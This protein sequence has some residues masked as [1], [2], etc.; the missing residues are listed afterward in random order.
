MP[1]FDAHPGYEFVGVAIAAALYVMTYLSVVRT[2]RY[3]RNWARLSFAALS[4]AITMTFLMLVH[5]SMSSAGLDIVTLCVL[6]GFISV[7]FY[8][9]SAPALAFKPASRPT[10]FLARHGEYAGLWML[11]PAVAAVITIP[12]AKLHAIV[13][14]AM[15]IELAWYLQYR[16]TKKERVLIPITGRDLA[17]LKMQ[18]N[19]DIKSYARRHGI[20]E[21]ELTG[22]EVAWRGCEKT[23]SHC[24]LNLYV[25]RLGLNTTPCCREHMRVL[26]LTV[27]TWMEELGIVYWLEGGTL[28][29]A[30]REGG[31]LLPWE[32]DVDVSVLIEDDAAWGA[33]AI[34]VAACGE[35]DGYLVDAFKRH[36][37]IAI[38]HA[39][40]RLSPCVGRTTD[41]AVKYVSILRLTDQV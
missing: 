5:T 19:G 13:A 29:G 3:P 36:G 25:N 12:N 21:L 28:L 37:F 26:C 27:S 39:A 6:A 7:L 24:P 17:V 23:S 14:V 1:S 32:D 16:W 38:T 31:T 20:S 34:G 30:V 9:I 33:L 10:E 4:P 41:C 11:V 22:D 18:A 2:L 15:T 8:I 35:R 40:S